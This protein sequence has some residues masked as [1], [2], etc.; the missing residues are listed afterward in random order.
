M[1]CQE[2]AFNMKVSGQTSGR[3]ALFPSIWME[4]H[5]V[6]IEFRIAYQ[7]LLSHPFIY[8]FPKVS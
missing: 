6:S 5:A 7:P 8:E 1:A 3:I 4:W 2:Y